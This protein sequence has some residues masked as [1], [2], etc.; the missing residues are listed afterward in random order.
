MEEIFEREILLEVKM[1]FF[2]LLRTDIQSFSYSE[3]LSEMLLT[4]QSLLKAKEVDFFIC[5]ER[6]Q[7][8]TRAATRKNGSE[9]RHLQTH[10]NCD[11]KYVSGEHSFIR[12]PHII[13]GFEKY[14]LVIELAGDGEP[15]GLLAFEMNSD[16]L[17]SDWLLNMISQEAA[18][19][20]K[21]IRSFTSMM[22][23]E[24]RYK[25]LFR[26]TEKFHSTMDMD[27]VL[28][29]I[30]AILQ[31]VYPSF[32]YYLLLSHDHKGYGGLPVKDLEYDSENL[33]AM[34]SYVSGQIQFEDSLT[35]KNSIM[36]APLKGKQGV[37]GVLQ[38]IAPD[39][40]VFP[41][42]E[43]EFI[44]LLANTAGSALENAKLYEQSR[45]LI[46]DLQLINETS[47]QL[48]SSLRL[49]DTMNFICGQIIKSFNA[50]EVGFIHWQAL[51]LWL[52]GVPF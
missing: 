23:E 30:I 26:V 41:H 51:K 32:T 2:D 18:S 47:H 21:K 29:E 43:V 24:K 44:K 31:E 36:Y 4:L 14:E 1:R 27:A 50:Q 17:A 39:A 20:V 52:K 28:G 15:L 19:Y 9:G 46:A 33:T 3:L 38:V 7:G 10:P 42:N 8:F 35:E 11:A 12:K 22:A 16:S 6:K 5:D 25:Q 34:Q 48:N 45:R 40:L 13:P 37:Y 49:A